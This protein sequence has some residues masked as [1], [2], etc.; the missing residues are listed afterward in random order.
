[1]RFHVALNAGSSPF[2]YI[3]NHPELQETL[4]MVREN[5]EMLSVL[6]QRVA[7]ENPE[8]LQVQ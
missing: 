6:L 5:P 8:L 4:N 1:M 7:Q 2:E 3:L